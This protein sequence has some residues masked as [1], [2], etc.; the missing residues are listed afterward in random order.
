[1]HIHTVFFWLLDDVDNA[2]REAFE[3]GLDRL[4]HESHV[5][6]RDIGKPATTDRDVVDSTY[7]YAIILR[8]ENI[9]G[10][11]AYQISTQHQEFLDTCFAMIN[12]VLVYDIEP[13]LPAD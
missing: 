7:D 3:N 9:A 11:N 5:L 10:H 2:G 4:T 8:F 13:D 12:R 1:M 6:D